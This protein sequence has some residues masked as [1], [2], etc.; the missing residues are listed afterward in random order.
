MDPENLSASEEFTPNRLIDCFGHEK[1]EE[2]KPYVELAIEWVPPRDEESPG[3][4]LWEEHKNGYVDIVEKVSIKICSSYYGKMPGNTIPYMHQHKA[5]FRDLESMLAR[6]FPAVPMRWCLSM[7][8]ETIEHAVDELIDENAET[9]IVIDFFHVYSSLEEFNALFEEV[10]DAVA[11]RAKVIFTPFPGAYASYRRAY[12]AMA[13]DEILPLPKHEKKL[14]ILTRHGFPEIPGDPYPELANVYYLNM[15]KEIEQAL[16]GTNTLVV[17]ADTD[18]AGDDMDADHKRLA[19][20]EAL[21]MALEDGYDH[22]VFLLV[23]FM[24]ENT[25]SIFAHPQESLEPLHF[26]YEGT[27]PYHDFDKPF[28]L[29]LRSGKTRVVSA[30]T[31]V[32]DRYRP[33]ISQGFY[34]AIATVLR[35]DEWPELVMEIEEKKKGMF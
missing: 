19:T 15:Q 13:Q 17:L 33:Y 14:M 6:E 8:P 4:F 2:G 26:K 12:V 32:G 31:P 28:R 3:H 30:G 16:E 34:D 23:D 11:E 1:N 7:Y 21:E 27:V 22:V 5:I 29:E 25:D 9:I 18:F 35:G 24:A 10:K 20:Y